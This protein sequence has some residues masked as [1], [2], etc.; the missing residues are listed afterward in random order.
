MAFIV[1]RKLFAAFLR[2]RS[3]GRHFRRLA[4]LDTVVRTG[5]SREVPPELARELTNAADSDPET[6]LQR[7]NSHVDGLTEPEASAVR[8]RVG[9]NE[10]EH[11]KPRN[12]S[13]LGPHHPEPPKR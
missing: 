13:L 3:F 8:A 10:V 2:T 12:L 1:L 5:I 6:L 9:P 7:L 4:L 11:E